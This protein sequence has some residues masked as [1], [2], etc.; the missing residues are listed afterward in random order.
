V[1]RRLSDFVLHF[2]EMWKLIVE[3]IGAEDAA[4]LDG[5]LLLS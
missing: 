5:Y 4:V 1:I 2:R 3:V